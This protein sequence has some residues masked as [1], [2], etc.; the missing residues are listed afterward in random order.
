MLV[1][2]VI[3]HHLGDDA[4]AAAMRLLQ[5]VLKIAQRAVGGMDVVVVGDIVAV[6][7]PG[8]RKEGQQP[9]GGDAQVLQVIQ[10]LGEAAEIA[11]AVVVAVVERADV[12]FIDDRVFVPESVRVESGVEV[13]AGHS[14]FYCATECTT[15]LPYGRG[16]VTSFCNR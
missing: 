14:F 7:A 8:E 10:F 13:V 1:G 16:S 4:H 6:V 3:Q 11:H 12:D 9:D 5:K 2:G 15:E